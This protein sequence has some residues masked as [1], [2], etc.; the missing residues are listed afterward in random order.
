VRDPASAHARA[1]LRACGLDP[2]IPDR[3]DASSAALEWARSGAMALTG[4]AEAAPRFVRGALASAARGAGLA[5][6]ALAPRSALA[7]LDAP[8]LLG[9][10]AA[11]SGLARQGL[12]SAGG[13]ARIMPTRDDH[14]VVNLAREDDWHLVPAWLE[15]ERREIASS[16]DVS[17]LERIVAT[18]EAASLVAR[19]RLMGLAVAPA[20]TTLPTEARLFALHHAS[21]GSPRR[22]ERPIRL[23][24]LSN[25]WAGPLATSL[26][27]MTGIDVLKIE[28]PK[29][30]DGAREGPRAFFDLLNAKKTAVALD[31]RIA[32]DRGIF[33]HLL[34]SADVVVESARPRALSQLGFD[35][36]D[37]VRARPG[38]LWTS[39]T[40][41]GRAHEWIAYGD[42]AAVAA[43]LAW[44]PDPEIED[45]VFPADAVADPL[46]GLH[47]AAFILAHLQQARGGLLEIALHDIAAYA[48]GLRFAEG[49]L[50]VVRASGPSGAS[51]QWCVL[52]GEREIA[53]AA[54]RARAVHASAR[55][56]AR[57]SDP[58]AE[59]RLAA[60]M[61]GC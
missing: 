44:S 34:A 32:R 42:D 50:P 38:R 3:E 30:P 19:G 39:I 11:L 37:W 24:D 61:A 9:E 28:D 56:L 53:I 26:V 20:P 25:L 48:G 13:R 54:P 18:R 55:P 7:S 15:V 57:P 33:E 49:C 4:P 1:L 12:V 2:T 47:T 14:L 29:R 52:D 5:L 17:V 36:A 21:Q 10:R 16:R 60:W 31:L 6:G 58:V 46:A 27:A 40:G 35:A 8:A 43:G 45:P 23:L 59:E 22:H 41:Y 51:G